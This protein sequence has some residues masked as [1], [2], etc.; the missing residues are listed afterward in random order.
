MRRAAVI[1]LILLDLRRRP[2]RTALTSFGVTVG[3]AATVA[4][5]ALS[6]GIERTAA[7]LIHH[8]DYPVIVFPRGAEDSDP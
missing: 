4:L 7:E 2:G 1:R 8:A 3:V 5:L 6:A